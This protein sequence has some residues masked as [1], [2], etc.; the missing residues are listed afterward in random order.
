M[1]IVVGITG[2]SGYILGHRITEAIAAAGHTV[3]LIVSDSAELIAKI[4]GNDVDKTRK[5][6]ARAYGEHDLGAAISSS[7][8]APDAMIVAPC[9]LKT[10]SS[11]ATGY[12]DNLITRCA[13][14]C[15][16]MRRPLAVMVRETP[17]SLMAID[18][19]RT[20]ALAGAIILPPV[21]AYY[22]APQTV[23]DVTSFFVGKALD[24][25]GIEHD[26]PGWGGI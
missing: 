10:L 23:D 26:F 17:L 21:M 1:H 11:L 14:T 9:S 20:L 2:A 6:A 3:S 15:L 4:E 8:E 24:A 5:A 18:N 22:T 25:L 16:R 13:E 7:T 19:M 12:G